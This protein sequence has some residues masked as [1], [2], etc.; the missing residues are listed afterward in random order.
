MLQLWPLEGRPEVESIHLAGWFVFSGKKEHSPQFY[1]QDLL[2]TAGAVS[3]QLPASRKAA[4]DAVAES[5]VCRRQR[6]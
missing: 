1:S 4:V 3:M 2:N 6:R 5:Q